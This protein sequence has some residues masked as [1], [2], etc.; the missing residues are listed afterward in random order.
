[1]PT[2]QDLASHTIPDPSSGFR[3]GSDDDGDMSAASPE[4]QRLLVRV[5]QALV[6]AGIGTEDLTIDIQQDRVNIRGFVA[7]HEEGVKV[8]DVIRD[9][10]GVL[11]VYEQLVVR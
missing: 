6:D 3:A 8:G 4:E 5:Q 1:M 11:E 10:P 7:T 9:V 2:N